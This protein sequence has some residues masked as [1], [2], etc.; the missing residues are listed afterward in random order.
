MHIITEFSEEY[1][2]AMRPTFITTNNEVEYES[3]L[4]GLAVF[5]ALGVK[6]IGVKADSQVVVNESSPLKARS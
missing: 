1:D 6:E 4:A 3:L 5:K 2:Y